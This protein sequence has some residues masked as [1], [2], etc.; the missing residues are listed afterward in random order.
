[1]KPI[2]RILPLTLMIL[3]ICMACSCKANS[4]EQVSQ[5]SYSKP[6]SISSESMSELKQ[7]DINAISFTPTEEYS[8]MDFLA[9]EQQRVFWQ[10]DFI[11]TVFSSDSSLFFSAS[12]INSDESVDNR[13]YKTGYD[14]ESVINSFKSVLSE[15]IVNELIESKCENHDGEFV[16]GIG[17]KGINPSFMFVLEFEEVKANDNSVSFKALADYGDPEKNEITSQKEFNFQMDKVNGNW[18]VTRFEMWK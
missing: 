16:C 17:A 10:A 7:Y 5:S 6:D 15:D 9:E 14:Y 1:M 3:S 18:I 8:G 13:F 11:Y 4:D 2:K 12:G